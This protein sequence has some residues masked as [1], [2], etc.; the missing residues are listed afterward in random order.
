MHI[1][2]LSY[3]D[4]EGTDKNNLVQILKCYLIVRYV[5][6]KNSIEFS[7]QEKALC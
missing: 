6:L 7:I 1:I 3:P 5:C 4:L 2:A